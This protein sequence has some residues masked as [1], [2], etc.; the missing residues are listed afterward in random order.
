MAEDQIIEWKE[1]WRDDYLKWVCAFS[2]SQG[3]TLVIGKRDNGS[4]KGVENS[5]RL[6]ESLPNKILHTLG[7]VCDVNLK[8]EKDLE[9]IEIKVEPSLSPIAF[10]GRYFK[11]TGSTTQLLTGM[12]LSDFLMLKANINWDEVIIDSAKIEDIDIEAIDNFKKE[13]KKSGRISSINDDTS[14]IDVLR[15]LNLLSES[16]QLTRAAVILFGI[17]P[18]RFVHGA[19]V[20]IGRFGES[21]SDLRSQE[22]VEGNNFQLAEKV[23]E[24]LDNKYIIRNISYDGLKRIETPEYPF[25][26][27]REAI[28]NAVIHREYDSAAITVSVFDDRLEIWNDGLLNENLTIEELKTNHRSYPRNKLMGN[29]FYKAG[30]IESWGRGTIK[31]IEESMKMGL[32]EPKIHQYSGGFAITLYKNRTSPEFLATLDLNDRQLRA[33]NYFKKFE[34]FTSGE[35]QK[36]TEVTDRTALRDLNELVELKILKRTGKKRGVKY[37]VF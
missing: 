11:R 26:A 4:I 25:E 14:T 5:K 34:S 24:L 6:L 33:I 31:I 32:P 1:S 15:N 13:A 22:L 28:F 21:S 10:D 20:K 37:H 30:Y 19:V 3:G 2:N 29:V 36:E 12:A 27:I 16:G 8:I 9:Y 35:Y 23:I 7:V 17:N 18:G